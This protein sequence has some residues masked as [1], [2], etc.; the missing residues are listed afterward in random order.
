MIIDP[1]WPRQQARPAN[2]H[3]IKVLG[4]IAVNV[5]ALLLVWIGIPILLWLVAGA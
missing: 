4:A 3:L 2:P 1:R 5:T